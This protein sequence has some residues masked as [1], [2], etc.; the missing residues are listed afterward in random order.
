MVFINNMS[1][2]VITPINTAKQPLKSNLLSNYGQR[3]I[4][5]QIKIISF[6]LERFFLEFNPELISKNEQKLKDIGFRQIGNDIGEG[7]VISGDKCDYHVYS[8]SDD[9]LGFNIIEAGT[10][11]VRE[12]FCLDKNSNQFTHAGSTTNIEEEMSE[13]IDFI[14]K[15]LGKSKRECIKP[16]HQ[17][18]I[19]RSETSEK[20]EELNRTMRRAKKNVSIKDFGYIGD[21][22]KNIS[23]SIVN[24][25]K[26]ILELYKRIPDGHTRSKARSRYPNYITQEGTG[27]MGFKNIGPSGENI[28]LFYLTYQRANYLS[29]GI[30][31]ASGKELKFVIS[32]DKGTVQRNLPYRFS[33]SGS[34]ENRLHSIPD[35]YTQEEIDKS[36]M[37][38]YLSCLERELDLFREH[39]EK[40]INKW[41]EQKLIRLNKDIGT[42]EPYK[43]LLDDVSESFE[44]Y[45]VK[46]RK[47]LRKSNK[48]KQFKAENNISVQLTSTAVR[49]ENITPEGY[50]LR[51]SYPK[52]HDKNATQLLVMSGDEI[53]KSFYIYDNKL[54]RFNIKDLNDKFQN[55][56]HNLY[57]YDNKYLQ[58]SEFEKYFSLVRDKL[59]SLNL[60]LDKIREKQLKNIERYHIKSPK[61]K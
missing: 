13:T 55:C 61:E 7:I 26:N 44:K 24:K 3:F 50:D 28:N 32:E 54:L 51:L 4:K 33:V 36:E 9:K 34:K 52:V 58:E 5:S 59:H 23:E 46:I 47:Y 15:I 42:L 12:Y 43:E 20:I 39:S 18:F 2:V 41:E 22:E 49:F 1:P 30:T 48:R 53:K 6:A 21:K 11:Q 14:D 8:S 60:K 29:V 56:C 27:K 45:R 57:Y 17:I 19:P 31:N 10:N 37:N 38:S 16:I 25:Y 40:W 35:Y